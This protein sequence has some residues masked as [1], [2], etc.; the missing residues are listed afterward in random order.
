MLEDK[1][2]GM[3]GLARRAGK[4]PSGTVAVTKCLQSGKCALVLIDELASE[5][6][7]QELS[8][9]C[10]K[11]NVPLRAVPGG[12]I[13]KSLGEYRICAATNDTNFSA[14]ML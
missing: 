14:Q 3:I 10:E 9:L 6:T 13:E 7:K 4:L 1:L 8:R 11:A 12:L 2:K 5:G